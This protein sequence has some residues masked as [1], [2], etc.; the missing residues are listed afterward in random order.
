MELV[1]VPS[2]NGEPEAEAGRMFAAYTISEYEKTKDITAVNVRFLVDVI[3]PGQK[4]QMRL[5][6]GDRKNDRSKK[7]SELLLNT[8]DRKSILGEMTAVV[9]PLHV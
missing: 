1:A 8:G 5:R 3:F 9:M 7:P 2:N 4:F 6:A